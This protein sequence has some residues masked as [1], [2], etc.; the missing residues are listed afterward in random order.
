M[1]I[2]AS[3]VK[4]LRERTGA[5]MMDC[6]NALT[7][8]AG[9]IEAAIQLLREKGAIKAAK[10][11][12]RI[13]AEGLI[14]FA[15]SA[16]HRKAALVEVNCETD[17]V[18]RAEDFIQ[19]THR[20]AQLALEHN[21]KDSNQLNNLVFDASENLSVEAKR[22]ALIAKLGENIN[23]RRI[24]LVTSHGLIGAYNHG[25]RIGVL[26]AMKSGDMSL[27][28]D[29][30]M[31]VAALQPLVVSPTEISPQLIEKERE[32]YTVQ[33]AE[34]GKPADIIA[35]MVDGRIKKYLDEVSLLGQPFVKDQNIS[36]HKVLATQKAEVE[37]FVRFEVGEGVEKQVVDFASEV[38]AQVK[39]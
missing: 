38:M 5:A 14:A 7:S 2:S 15:V 13:T 4:E 8:T 36:V 10:K 17:F 3:L 21:A 12:D 27:A 29:L 28:K 9:D 18:A 19:F 26:V 35:K 30:A 6:K 31:H 23:I 25:N 22:Q 32:I 11:G 20:V 34:S 1:N 39:G 37:S 33:A 24:A 16:D